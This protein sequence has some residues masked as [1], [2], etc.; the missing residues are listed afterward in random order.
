MADQDKGRKLIPPKTS[1]QRTIVYLVLVAVVA[2]ILVVVALA[3]AA[4]HAPS[5]SSSTPS[6]GGLY[7]QNT[8]TSNQTSQDIRVD[9]FTSSQ[10]TITGETTFLVTV[11]NIGNSTVT[12]DLNV[13]VSQTSGTSA[14]NQPYPGKETP[15]NNP[16]LTNSTAVTIAPGETRTVPVTVQTPPGFAVVPGNVVITFT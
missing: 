10:N 3:L 7:P 6:G 1:R 2:I 16:V 4:P 12:R 9:N 8:R 15:T 5:G 11:T 14:P 13:A